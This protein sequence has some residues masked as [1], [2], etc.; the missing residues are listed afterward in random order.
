[1]TALELMILGAAGPKLH[2]AILSSCISGNN[3]AISMHVLRYG[4]DTATER[5]CPAMVTQ[6]I[7][8]PA[9]LSCEL[10]TGVSEGLHQ[11]NRS[12]CS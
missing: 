10:S 8:L 5:S 9:G 7:P 6:G 2:D 12:C 3:A 4:C 11:L 1:M